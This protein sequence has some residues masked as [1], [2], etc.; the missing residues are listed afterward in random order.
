MTI[1]AY[2]GLPG[3]GKS[4]S[5]V[6][7]QILPA[8][9]AGRRVV[10]NVAMRWDL[11]RSEF[12]DADLVDL[13]TQRVQG[14]PACLYEYVTPG[15]VLVLDEVWRLFPAGEK[16]NKVPEPYRKLLAEHR[17]MVNGKGDACQI[18]LVTQDLAQISKFARILI[19]NT[20]RTVKL[21]TVGLN[22]QFRV[23]VYRGPAEGPNPP[24]NAK[25]R[26][27]FGTYREEVW[28]YYESNTMRDVGA[29]GIKANEKSVD[30]RANVLRRP[31]VLLG[32]LAVPLLLG[33]GF[34]KL[35]SLV[36]KAEAVPIVATAAEPPQ[37]TTATAPS[38]SPVAGVG[39]VSKPVTRLPPPGFTWRLAGVVVNLDNAERSRAIVT[40]GSKLFVIPYAKQCY[41]TPDGRHFCKFR[42][43]EVGEFG[44][45]GSLQNKAAQPRS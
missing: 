3:S 28:K 27:V 39:P 9:K 10:T 5:V 31:V 41:S 22:G 36:N 24:E 43:E 38:S 7:H 26:Q 29:A 25:L 8:L 23:D 42:G 40:D 4:Y 20:F 21:T 45:V 37:A 18:V 30:R 44:I 15:S 14:D 35:S 12:P 2:T 11:C 19:D 17:H 6:E 33:V 32:A 1:Y 34:W 16:A 13:P